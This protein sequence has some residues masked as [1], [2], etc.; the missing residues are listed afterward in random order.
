MTGPG[1]VRGKDPLGRDITLEHVV[2]LPVLGVPVRFASNDRLVATEVERRYGVWRRLE[3][4]S[5]L[6][7]SGA[8]SVRL[9]VYHD[10]PGG[11]GHSRLAYRLPDP[12]RL[13]AFGPGAFGVA[14]LGRK[15]AVAYVTPALVAASDR[16]HTE[17]LETITL[18]LA[19]HEDRQPLHAAAVTRGGAALLLAGPSGIGKST[20][21][22][23]AAAGGFD[24]L[25][26]DVTYVQVRPQLRVWGKPGQL[27]LPPDAGKFFPGLAGL[28]PVMRPDGGQKLVV[29]TSV[30]AGVHGLVAFRARVCV[31][32]RGS[33]PALEAVN[34]AAI[35]ER[36][37]SSIE[38]GFDLF[39]HTIAHAVDVLAAP[40]GWC[41]TVG[42][43]PSAAVALL[44]RAMDADG[45][46]AE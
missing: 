17:L 14:D 45:W 44:R 8:V 20:L 16:F 21:A 43:S 33:R 46:T 36:L 41:L 7:A 12:D 1:G 30:P 34:A 27:G 2:L 28:V 4:N 25:S 31:L 5:A 18:F 22:Y 35:R 40:G 38:P 11:L 37:L 29:E 39:R 42:D 9:I 32:A 15:D 13:V 10:G 23:A 26:D 19:T 24:V 6:L 3:H